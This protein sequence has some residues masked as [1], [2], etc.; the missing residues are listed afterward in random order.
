MNIISNVKT[1][2]ICSSSKFYEA[3]KRVAKEL[4]AAGLEVYTPRFDFD[5]EKVTVGT[6]DKMRLT[7]EFLEKIAKSDAVYVVAGGGYT[8]RS[9]CIEVG[10]AFAQ[11][12]PVILSEVAEE[13]AIKA[14]TTAVAAPE[15]LPTLL[16]L[17]AA[18]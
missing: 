3:A 10:Y 5:E 6:E 11:R 12:K 14:L 1:L 13:G 9:V 8:G 7:H 16:G 2:T 17:V 4:E 18:R 15:L